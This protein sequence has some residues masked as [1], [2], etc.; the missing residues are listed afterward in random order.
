MVGGIFCDLQKAF[1]S[2]NYDILLSK[3]EYYGIKGI[4]KAFYQ[5]YLQNRYQ[6]ITI[7]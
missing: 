3:L 7:S 2:V 6:S 5:S 4:D 1:D